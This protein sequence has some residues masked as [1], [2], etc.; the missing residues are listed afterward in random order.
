MSPTWWFIRHDHKDVDIKLFTP[1]FNNFMSTTWWLIRHVHIILIK[2]LVQRN[3]IIPENCL[4]S[5]GKSLLRFQKRKLFGYFWKK[6]HSLRK[7]YC[8]HRYLIFKS[9]KLFSL[10]EMKVDELGKLPICRNHLTSEKFYYW[11]HHPAKKINCS[12]NLKNVPA[13]ENQNRFLSFDKIFDSPRI[14]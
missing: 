6:I 2:F 14:Q 12:E 5:V 8:V 3:F 1:G 9:R 4:A 10:F 11:F 7:V 13:Q